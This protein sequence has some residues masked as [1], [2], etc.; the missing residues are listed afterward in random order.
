L[1]KDA[2]AADEAVKAEAQA[3]SS[4]LSHAKMRGSRALR[5]KT[6]RMLK[7]L[8]V[9]PEELIL[10]MIAMTRERIE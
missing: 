3:S 9:C 2:A 8:G 5:R 7:Y 4:G 6:E 10:G 1:Q